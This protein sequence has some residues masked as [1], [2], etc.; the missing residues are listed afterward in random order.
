MESF[1]LLDVRTLGR[2]FSQVKP[3]T[4]QLN[5]IPTRFLKHFVDSLRISCYTLR[6]FQKGYLMILF[7]F[8]YGSFDSLII[9]IVDSII[10]ATILFNAFFSIQN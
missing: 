6:V 10:A 4:C 2:V 8:N 3:T 1:A 5:P 9:T 7:N